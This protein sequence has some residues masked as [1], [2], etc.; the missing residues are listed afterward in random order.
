MSKTHR[1]FS[2][3]ELLA[4][5]RGCGNCAYFRRA[6]GEDWGECHLMPPVPV[7]EHEYDGD[8]DEGMTETV[9]QMN[10]RPQVDTVDICSKWE[11]RDAS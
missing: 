7:I 9:F 4:A 6:E 1:G 8:E 5:P 10:I 3:D 11:T 2:A